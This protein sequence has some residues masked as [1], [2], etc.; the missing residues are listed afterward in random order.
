MTHD[1]ALHGG[2]ICDGY[3][4]MQA[5]ILVSDG[6]IKAIIDSSDAFSAKEVVDCRDCFVL[7]GFIDPHVHLKLRLGNHESADDFLGGSELALSGGVT[8]FI[9]FLD[10]GRDARELRNLFKDRLSLAKS[11]KID[12]SFHS[13]IAGD[14]LSTAEEF[15]SESLLLGCPT[16]KVFTTYSESGRMTEDG[17]LIDLLEQSR[18]RGTVVLV[19]AENDPI[20]QHEIRKSGPVVTWKDLGSVRPV[21]TEREAVGRMSVYAAETGGQVYIVHVSAGS[22]ILLASSIPGFSARNIVFETCPQYVVFTDRSLK[23]DDGALFGCVPPLRPAEERDLLIEF[24]RQGMV[25]TLGTDHC[26][27]TSAEK[28]AAG[29]LAELP[30][31][32]GSLGL[33]ASALWTVL[34]E[35]DICLLTRMMSANAAK[36][37]GLYPQKGSLIPG[38]DADIVVFDPNSCIENLPNDFTACDYSPYSGLSMTG[39]VVATVMRGK[40]A[41][42]GQYVLVPEGYGAFIAREQIDWSEVS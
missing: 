23:S 4:C 38:T 36:L 2:T 15:T 6:K 34:E 22:S 16:I 41:Y 10:P 37:L 13:T 28:L 21:I 1:L 8:T 35:G 31:G 25:S 3:T 24:V 26:P 33:T 14:P 39:K 17:F 19:H 32:L 20:I 30:L 12:F 27:F 5:T 40:L 18:E 9:D 11:S 7:P 29:S 42:D